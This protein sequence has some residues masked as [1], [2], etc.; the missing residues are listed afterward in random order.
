MQGGT[1]TS[2]VFLD[3]GRLRR[4]LDQLDQ[5]VLEDD[6]SWSDGEIAADLK[7]RFVNPRNAPL[8]EILDQVLH[9]GDQTLG[10]R[11]DSGSDDFRVG[12]GKIRRTHRVDELPRIEAKL[13]L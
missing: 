10:A 12:R 11:L 2:G 9:P 4:I 13:E 7:G 5:F 6:R 8:L 1:I 3:V